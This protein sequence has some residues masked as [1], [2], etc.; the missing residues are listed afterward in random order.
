ML[1]EVI[2]RPRA[3]ADGFP[4]AE[5]GNARI[6]ILFVAVAV[7]ELVPGRIEAANSYNF[8]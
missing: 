4:A 8:V 1:Y 3:G 5:E 6:E 7:L 2:T